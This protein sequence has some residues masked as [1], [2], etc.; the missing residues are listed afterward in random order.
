N[1]YHVRICLAGTRSSS[2]RCLTI[3]VHAVKPGRCPKPKKIPVCAESCYDD[4]QCPATKKCCPTTCG[5]ACSEPYRKGS[6]RY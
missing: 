6:R 4:G 5:H 2:S 3:R 1:L